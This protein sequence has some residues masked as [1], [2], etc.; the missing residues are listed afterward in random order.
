M[1]ATHQ[2]EH[3]AGS[4]I[5]NA[6]RRLSLFL[7]AAVACAQSPLIGE[8]T[9]LNVDFSSAAKESHCK[10]KGSFDGVLPD[11]CSENFTSWTE[12]VVKSSPLIEDGRKFLRIDVEKFDQCV[13]FAVPI[14]GLQIP[15]DYR[16]VVKVRPS[17]SFSVGL[18]QLP[19]PYKMLWSGQI[20]T[21][22][23]RWVERAFTFKLEAKC[24]SPIALFVYPD[25]GASDI[26]SVR[27]LKVTKEEVTTE[28]RRPDKS[29]RNFFRN[30]RFPL[31]I[32]SGWNVT[33]EFTRGFFGQD[34]TNPGPSGAPSLKLQSDVEISLCSE[35]F[36]TNAP[37]V[38]HYAS[39]ACKGSG[40]WKVSL[41][42]PTGKR[43][44]VREFTPG[45]DWK[46]EFMEFT[47]DAF[48][49]AF[50]L[51]FTGT[52]VL[53]LDSLQACAGPEKRSYLSDGECEVA[54]APVESEIS[55]T[56]I[57]FDDEPAKVKYCA[58]GKIEGCV[59]KSKAANLYG[60]EK[61]LPDID[62]GKSVIRRPSATKGISLESSSGTLDFGVFPETPYGQFRIEVWA[63]KGGKRVSPFNELLIT[64]VRKPVYWGKDAPDSPFGCHFYASPL[65]LKMMKA[66]GVNWVRLNDAGLEYIGWWKLEPEKG[67]W[68]FYDDDIQRYRDG[69]IKIFGQF[70]TA[71]PWATH[72]NELGLKNVGYFETF[73]RP[74]NLDDFANYVKVVTARYKG[75]ID[76]YFVWN[77]PWGAWWAKGLDIKLYPNGTPESDFAALCKAAHAAVKSVDPSI[78]ISG[79]NSAAGQGKWTQGVYEAGGLDFC[80]IVDYHFYTPKLTC[81]PGDQAQAS[82]TGAVGYIKQKCPTFNKPVYMSEGQGASAG[83]EGDATI[84]YSGLHKHTLPWLAQ[85]DSA[86]LADLNCR[87]AV[88][89]LSQ[90]V[91][92]VF[93]YSAH[94]YH[95]LAASTSFLVLLGADGYPHPALVAHANM[96]LHLE[97]KRFIRTASIGK[98]V[99]AYIFEG[100][101][102]TTAVVSGLQDGVYRVP[103]SDKT[104]SVDLFGNPLGGNA[105][106][107]GT[108]IFVGSKLGPDALEVVL[109]SK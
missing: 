29:T 100:Q 68:T 98:N 64:R 45:K 31:G 54:L 9:L 7:L 6:L 103:G 52:G 43:P 65:T 40:A 38:K 80:D 50:S 60:T 57:Q 84:S 95:T 18:R 3:A 41:L 30:T 97:G 59:L 37:A 56:R 66:G 22:G 44:F 104:S 96:A 70:G 87:F 16:V 75:V 48:S 91:S 67:K 20:R 82:Y 78:K 19:S 81:Y 93:L 28:V 26:E 88:S 5:A 83:S 63:E 25:A 10:R 74:K 55:E 21:V 58:T 105:E 86:L 12:S 23:R 77:E 14:V 53:L 34:E 11:G 27:L 85:D 71:P 39:F 62:L 13:Q 109:G 46:T 51:K 79:F 69:K 36:Q 76:E 4:V 92:K 35:P 32:Q 99:F 73:L 102:G 47:P 89:L 106:F 42:L 2:E 101:D 61:D 15:G 72:F 49:R 17:S 33:R 1:T 90:N 94:C 24:D 108:L 8:E 107:K